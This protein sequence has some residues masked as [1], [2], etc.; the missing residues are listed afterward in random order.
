MDTETTT[1]RR[2]PGRPRVPV[3]E[4]MLVLSINIP[5]E[6]RAHLDSLS[7]QCNK[8]L[9]ELAREAISVYIILNDHAREKHQDFKY[10]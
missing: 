4:R 6:L 10:V 3:S 8:S 7:N 9:S 1:V 5:P 2:R